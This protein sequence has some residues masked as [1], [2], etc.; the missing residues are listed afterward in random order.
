MTNDTNPKTPAKFEAV[1]EF[2]QT[3]RALVPIH[4]DT[5]VEAEDN[6]NAIHA[7]DVESWNFVYDDVQ[8]LDVR[9]AGETTG[10]G[11]DND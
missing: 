6:A 8:V 1:L 7:D 9:P 2:K 11:V 4:A 5:L 10:E 3:S